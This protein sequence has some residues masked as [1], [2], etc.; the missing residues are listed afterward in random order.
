MFSE[1]EFSPFLN[2]HRKPILIIKPQTDESLNDKFIST[3]FVI[4]IL[5]YTNIKN[6][7]NVVNEG[8]L[9]DC[10]FF[11]HLEKLH[12]KF[13]NFPN[14]IEAIVL[15]KTWI[16]KRNISNFNGFLFS[17]LMLYLLNKHVLNKHMS[18]F[19]ILKVAFNWIKT[20]DISNGI[21]FN[22]EYI[23]EYKEK[24]G[25]SSKLIFLDDQKFNLFHR[26]SKNEWLNFQ[27]EA[28]LSMKFLE[29]DDQL[30]S[31][32]SLF[33]NKQTFMLKY[34]FVLEI[35]NISKNVK[36]TKV[37]NFSQSKLDCFLKDIEN[38]LI[39]ALG[40]RVAFINLNVQDDTVLVG[41]SLKSD[42][43]DFPVVKGP[44]PKDEEKK[45]IFEEFWG[46]KSHIRRFKDSTILLATSNFINI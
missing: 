7:E 40:D 39:Y 41:I 22:E 23:E 33:L 9:E 8:I 37:M 13:K 26:L 30:L 44:H 12:E 6:I 42:D 29:D 27:N 15:Y 20:N 32:E 14:M 4:R 35:K 3:K 17:M 31:I 36:E 5:P 38:K 11:Q 43:W 10:Y 34:D 18:S 28:K 2:D 1:T 19:Q 45:K 21:S 16:K 24:Y 25:E 46:E